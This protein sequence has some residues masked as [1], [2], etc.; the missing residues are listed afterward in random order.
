MKLISCYVEGFGAI[1]KQN[2]EFDS[3]LTSV[4]EANGYGKTT[5]AAFLEA[6]FYGM[7]SDRANSKDFGVRRHFAPF[8]GGPFGGN[9]VFSMGEDRYKIERF[10][11]EKSENKDSLTVYKNNEPYTD[12]GVNI[13]EKIFGID[14]PSFE[15][16]AFIDSG[17]IEISSTGSINAKLNRFVEGGEDANTEKALELLEKQAKRYKKSRMGS[18][19]ISFENAAILDL[20]RKIVNAQRIRDNLPEKYARLAEYDRVR[21][22]RQKELSAVQDTRVVLKDWE[23]YDALV[24][25]AEKNKAVLAALDKKYPYGIPSAEE[26]NGLR[27][28]ISAMNTLRNQSGKDLS[29]KDVQALSELQAR[30]EHGVP[31]AEELDGVDGAIGKLIGLDAEIRSE[32]RTTDSEYEC[33]LRAKFGVNPPSQTTLSETDAALERYEQ[34]EREYEQTPDYTIVQNADE[35]AP[36]ANRKKK[37][38]VAAI[39]AAVVAAAGVGVLFVQRIAGFA[40]IA[41]GIL[42]LVAAGFLYLN[43]KMSS[44]APALPM[45]SLNPDKAVKARVRNDA[46]LGVQRILAVYGYSAENDVRYAV[47]KFKNDVRAYAALCRADAE[48][49]N[50]VSQKK[51]EREAAYLRLHE[52]FLSFGLEGNDV[53]ALSVRL[54]RDASAYITLINTSEKLREQNSQTERMAAEAEKRIAEICNKYRFDVRTIARQSEDISADAAEYLQ[55]K[56][57]Y[58]TNLK[59]AE[60]L[61]KEKNLQERPSAA[62]APT[63]SLEEEIAKLDRERSAL[64]AAIRE[65]EAEAEKLDDL[66]AEKE[67][68]AELLKKYRYDHAIVT[69]TAEYLKVADKRLKD[70]YVAPVKNNFTEYTELLEKALGERITMTPNFEIR[71][72]RNGVERSE[73]HL[74]AGQRSICAFCFRMALIENM[75][76]DEKPFLILDDPFVNLDGE[77]LEKVKGV[78]NALSAKFQI[79]YFTCHES[80][81]I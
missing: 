31:S 4:C 27:D 16:T 66:A 62:Y 71:Y 46:A 10:F 49:E 25:D 18:D 8:G 3:R 36:A 7:E 59:Q 6:M 29:E 68:H 70:R 44:S 38:A 41:L 42:G 22:E 61:C 40:L 57:A 30:F 65:D 58:V 17:E 78:L 45:Q 32:E 2:I 34:A 64:N 54:R 60:R 39:L 23:R 1:R 79:L 13:G 63:D 55:A 26:R 12:F 11:D 28:A 73:K 48:K 20:E 56:N 50:R 76:A 53:R 77:H 47:E 15:R 69:A 14:K 67:R 35:T 51:R 75:Y 52:Y 74:S 24:A 19:L 37:Y 72:E 33:E 9:V 43:R 81:A 21:K 5:L 80:R